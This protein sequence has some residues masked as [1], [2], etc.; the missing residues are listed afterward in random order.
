MLNLILQALAGQPVLQEAKSLES[1]PL[2]FEGLNIDG[3]KFDLRNPEEVIE[4]EKLVEKYKRDLQ[5][6]NLDKYEGKST[7]KFGGGRSSLKY[8]ELR[9]ELAKKYHNKEHNLNFNSQHE[10]ALKQRQE[11][12]RKYNNA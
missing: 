12:Y 6:G 7:E 8:D 11:E 9:I 2:R 3:N 5:S 1:L 4:A 10:E